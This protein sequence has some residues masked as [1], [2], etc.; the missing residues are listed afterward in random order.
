MMKMSELLVLCRI[1]TVPV[2]QNTTCNS[3]FPMY[4]KYGVG[5]L[6]ISVL[7]LDVCPLFSPP[8]LVDGLFIEEYR[9]FGVQSLITNTILYRA[10]F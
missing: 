10:M 6:T 2:G 3:H 5:D 1:L 9:A 7:D 4:Y 8:A